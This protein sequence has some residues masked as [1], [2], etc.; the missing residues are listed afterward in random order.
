MLEQLDC[1]GQCQYVSLDVYRAQGEKLPSSLLS[2]VKVIGAYCPTRK[3]IQ[4]INTHTATRFDLTSSQGFFVDC[5]NDLVDINT[6][7]RIGR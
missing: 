4:T 5:V 6:H 1:I 3:E 2:H 7:K